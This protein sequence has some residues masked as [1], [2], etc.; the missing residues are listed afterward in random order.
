MSRTLTTLLLFAVLWGTLHAEGFVWWE[1]ESAA[2]TNFPAR[3]WFSAKGKETDVL[4]GGRWLSNE[5]KR[6][7]P[8]A[9]AKYKVAVPEEGE[10]ALWTRKF[11]KHG[12]FRWRFDQG[13][14]QTCGRD[15]GLADSVTLRKHVCAN[16]VHL[17][18][19][20]LAKG[21]HTFELRLLAKEGEGLTAAF[22]CFLL[23][24]R[25][26]IPRGRLRPGEISGLAEP[27]WWA[28]EVQI[29]GA[30][31][32]EIDRVSVQRAQKP[33]GSPTEHNP[34]PGRS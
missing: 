2:E 31:G 34:R 28:F 26:F 11:W 12:S 3:T 30:S 23:T 1:G 10:Y 21:K 7:G 6:K 18:K 25:T 4:S 22:D 13:V 16:W 32:E 27:G 29:T 20:K 5:G 17:G 15:A 14:W 9:F 24:G 19:V 33:D 8:E